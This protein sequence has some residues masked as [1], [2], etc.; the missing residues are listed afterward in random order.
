MEN[1]SIFTSGDVFERFGWD[2]EYCLAL[3]PY[4]I[5]GRVIE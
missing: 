5:E 2:E 1:V 4:S 3:G